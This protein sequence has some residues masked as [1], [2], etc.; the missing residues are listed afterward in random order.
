MMFLPKKDASYQTL[1]RLYLRRKM[2]IK[3]HC[4]G[5]AVM[6]ITKSSGLS[7]PTVRRVIDRYIEGGE[8]TIRPSPRGKQLGEGRALNNAQECNL[9]QIIC[10]TLP[11]RLVMC[12]ALWDRTHV[13]SL[14]EREYKIKLSSRCVDSYIQRWKFSSLKPFNMGNKQPINVKIWLEEKYQCVRQRAKDEGAEIVWVAKKTLAMP[15]YFNSAI[16]ALDSNKRLL[17]LVAVSNQSKVRWMMFGGAITPEKLILFFDALIKSVD[18]KVF[19]IMLDTPVLHKKQIN[20]WLNK[21][22]KQLK[23]TPIP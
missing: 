9:Y 13:K 21:H 12:S 20:S 5:G 15:V 1:D 6:Q 18:R 17:Q 3:M 11:E 4:E 16:V 8:A 14:I 7:Y 10:D 19:L 2:I 23:L 22:K